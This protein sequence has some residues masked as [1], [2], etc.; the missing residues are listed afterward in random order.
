MF[1]S[2]IWI[3]KNVI[4]VTLTL[5]P[6]GLT[7]VFHKLLLGFSKHNCQLTKTRYLVNIRSA[8]RKAL[9]MQSQRIMAKLAN[10]NW[11]NHSLHPRWAEKEFGSHVMRQMNY[12]TRRPHQFPLWLSKNRNLN[13]HF[14]QAHRNRTADDWESMIWFFMHCTTGTWLAEYIIA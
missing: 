8:D 4:S 10:D 2:N 3:E 14:A 9:S 1:T 11:Y 7:W 5:M 13:L 12:N 6:D